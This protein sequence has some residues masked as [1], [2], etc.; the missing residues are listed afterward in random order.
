MKTKLSLRL[1]LIFA[2]CPVPCALCQIPQGFNY[3]AIARDGSGTILANL[4]LPVKI[5][6]QTSLTGGTLI[7]EE[8][9]SSVTSNSFGL[10]SLVIGTGSQTGGSAASFSAIDWKS[11]TLFLKTIIQYPGT[12]WTT[13]GTSQIWAVPYSLTAKEVTG[14]LTKLG[15]TGTTTD[16]EEAL[17]EVK[18]QAGNTVFAVYNEGIRAYVGNGDAKGKKGG[19]AVGGYDGTKGP[20]QNLMM[21]TG[22]SARIYVNNVSKKGAK[23]GFSVGGYDATKGGRTQDLLMVNNDSVRIYLNQSAGKGARGGFSV[24]GYDMSKGVD[25][26]FGYLDVSMDSTKTLNPSQNR[27]K[28]Y[29]FKNAFLVGK[30]LIEKPDSV[31]VNSF[32][33]GYESKAIGR[34]SEALGFR[35]IAR[36]NYSTA[37]GTNAI[38]NS[39]NCFALGGGSRANKDGSY[40]IGSG[41]TANGVGSYAI[42][43]AGRDTLGNLTGSM[44]TAKGDYSFAIGQGAT[45]SNSGSLAIGTNC[46]SSGFYSTAIGRSDTARGDQSTAM[47]FFTS[48][49]GHNSTAMG[50]FTTAS[51]VYSTSMGYRTTASLDFS[52]AMGYRTTA[53]G[54][55]STA[56]GYIT[57]A[58]GDFSIAMG[59]HTTASGQYSTA[60]GLNTTASGQYSTAMGYRTTASLDYATA[61]GYNTTASGQYSTAMG[62][63]TTASGQ[64]STAMG[65]YTTASGQYSTAMGSLTTASGVYSTAMGLYTTAPSFCET[66][67]GSFNTSY[68]PLSAFSWNTAD[69]LFVIGNGANSSAKSNAVTVY[70]NGLTDIGGTL[71]VIG[72][73]TPASGAGVEIYYTGG[74]GYLQ[75]YDRTGSAYKPL[76]IC[77]GLVRPITDNAYALGS[78]SY[79]WTAVYAAN[80]TIQTSDRRMKENITTLTE[81]LKTVLNL[82]PVYFTWKDQSDQNKHIGL[83]AQEVLPLV[84][85]VV[86]T[87][88][89]PDKTMGINYAGLVP[90]LIKGMQEQQQQIE[91]QKQQ[92]RQLKTELQAMKER[93]DRIEGMM[94]DGGSK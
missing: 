73:V 5:D 23:G 50:S 54:H 83:I 36:K 17:F 6:I 84:P 61:M 19:F 51:G 48:A 12:T 62:Y 18:N 59:Y 55:N 38:A 32:A 53:S 71:R 1:L 24:G 39:T 42:G 68:S 34:Y 33:C 45:A 56:M 27:I 20:I 14:P 63:Y 66:V 79:R 87:G 70:K 52:T 80:G 65:Y 25:T 46:I 37:I 91:S 16:M 88:N 4:A 44:T 69:R 60:M 67:I 81:G 64:Y 21:I 47:G 7:Y 92:N 2:L 93:L 90:V 77:S 74:I 75:C 31:G 11:Q 86:D 72:S 49:S 26:S 89:D 35:A 9:F 3:Q 22:D 40:A 29:P 82:N 58:S 43:S 10:I 57:I 13:M 41:A 78:S 8:L 76:T 85:E 15:I 94:A 28:F 30:V